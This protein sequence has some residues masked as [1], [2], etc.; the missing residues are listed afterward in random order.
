MMPATFLVTNC[1]LSEVVKDL[2]RET[3]VRIGGEG[4]VG[5]GEWWR[6]EG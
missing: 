2:R 1:R 4:D 5:D 3:L 6:K